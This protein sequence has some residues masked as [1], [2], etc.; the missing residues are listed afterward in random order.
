MRTVFMT[1]AALGFLLALL[2][3]PVGAQDYRSRVQ[4][5]VIDQSQAAV[6][7]ATV[8]LINEGTKVSVFKVTDSVGHYLFDFVEPGTY[9]VT[10]EL[11]G[12]KKSERTGIRV[13]QRAD[14][15]ANLALSM[16]TLNET[17]TVVAETT[18]VR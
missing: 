9:T 7:G 13:Q 8:A 6:P 12:F 4:G 18:Q 3:V 15:A 17:V 14:V 5:I 2:F 11:T 10:A 16:G 1:L